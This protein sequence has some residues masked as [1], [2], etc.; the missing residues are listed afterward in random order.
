MW[1]YGVLSVAQVVH[2]KGIDAEYT[3]LEMAKRDS[4]RR[5]WPVS[6]VRHP[7]PNVASS[8]AVEKVLDQYPWADSGLQ[9]KGTMVFVEKPGEDRSTL[10]D[11]AKKPGVNPLSGPSSAGQ[12]ALSSTSPPAKSMPSASTKAMS[13]GQAT[14]SERP[15]S[16]SAA[17]GKGE[18]SSVPKATVPT[19]KAA[20]QG[21][22]SLQSL[23]KGPPHQQLRL[24]RYPQQRN[25]R[26]HRH[27][28]R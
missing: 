13:T 22:Q 11:S 9:W 23:K 6:M 14:S 25:H 8:T 27:R 7:V 28:L 26:A 18:G 17:T 3:L 21:S 10:F 1:T 5:V 19:S 15:A 12:D 24:E 16:E 2:R 4:A 20:S